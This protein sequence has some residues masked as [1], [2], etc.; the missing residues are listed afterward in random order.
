[1]DHQL[2]LATSGENIEPPALA[3]LEPRCWTDSGPTLARD[4]HTQCQSNAGQI[5]RLILFTLFFFFVFLPDPPFRC[6]FRF[7]APF[8]RFWSEHLPLNIK[9]WPPFPS[10]LV[11][12]LSGELSGMASHCLMPAFA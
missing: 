8:S 11:N 5:H 2:G 6:P 10:S 12:V 3:L 4:K 7:P 1:M 9:N